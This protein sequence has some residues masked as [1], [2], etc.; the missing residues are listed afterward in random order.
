MHDAFVKLDH[1]LS[2]VIAVLEQEE[3]PQDGPAAENELLDKLR[4]WRDFLDS[5]RAGPTGKHVLYARSPL[6]ET[7]EQETGMFAD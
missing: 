4:E 7:P 3:S 1:A 2:D 6:K 5:A